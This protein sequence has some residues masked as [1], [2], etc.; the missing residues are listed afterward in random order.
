MWRQAP[1]QMGSHT[2]KDRVSRAHTCRSLQQTYN[3]IQITISCVDQG[4]ELLAQG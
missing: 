4:G 1:L 3:Q 2:E